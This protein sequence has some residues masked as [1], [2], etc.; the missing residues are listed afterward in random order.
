[1]FLLSANNR[2]SGNG[3]TRRI[4]PFVNDSPGF[5][6]ST[7]FGFRNGFPGDSNANRYLHVVSYDYHP[8]I[9]AVLLCIHL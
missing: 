2:R 9:M 7:S 3:S 6:F 5:G 1:M 4:D 8:P